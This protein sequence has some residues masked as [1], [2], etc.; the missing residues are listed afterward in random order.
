M[1][2]FLS[3]GSACQLA[4][5]MNTCRFLADLPDLFDFAIGL[6]R[7]VVRAKLILHIA[8]RSVHSPTTMVKTTTHVQNKWATSV[9]ER[10][11]K[12]Q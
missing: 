1:P 3:A 12:L 5:A 2:V 10:K 7:W 6:V 8:D 4:Y 11:G 9:T